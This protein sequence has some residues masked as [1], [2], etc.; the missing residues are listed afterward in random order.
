MGFREKWRE[1]AGVLDY[2]GLLSLVGGIFVRVS[3][4]TGE[5]PARRGSVYVTLRHRSLSC[6]HTLPVRV[7]SAVLPAAGRF[8]AA[9]R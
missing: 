4:E 3:Y 2:A 7:L 5:A 1:A 6:V 9:D 8:R